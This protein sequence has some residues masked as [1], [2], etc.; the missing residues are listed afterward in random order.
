MLDT[1]KHV[2]LGFTTNVRI[3]HR[4]WRR[5]AESAVWFV[6]PTARILLAKNLFRP[7]RN[8]RQAHDTLGFMAVEPAGCLAT[9][10]RAQRPL[11]RAAINSM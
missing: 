8:V 3:E 5:P 1:S 11:K 2:A 7:C 9:H 10:K 6:K 4:Y